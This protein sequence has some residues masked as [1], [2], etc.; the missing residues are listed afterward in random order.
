MWTEGLLQWQVEDEVNL[1][2]AETKYLE[3]SLKCSV[4]T[5]HIKKTEVISIL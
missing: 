3:H 2:Y 5:H 1:G 4:G